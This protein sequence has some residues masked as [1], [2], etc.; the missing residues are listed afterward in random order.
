VRILVLG[1][2]RFLGRGAVDAA[3]ARGHQVTLFN[4]GRSS[5]ELYP[6]VEHLRGDRDG[7]LTPL[8]GRDFDA[9]IDTSGFLPRVVRASCELLSDSVGHYSFVSTVGVYDL[10]RANTEE[11]WTKEPDW[12]T[13][14]PTRAP[15]S[16]YQQRKLACE[17]V[18]Q[19]AF[20]RRAF[21]PRPG[22]IVGAHDP[23]RRL[24]YW[25]LRLLRGGDVLA[26]APRELPVQ[27]IDAADLGDWMVQASERGVAGVFTATGPAERLT[28]ESFLERIRRALGSH[29]RL[30]WVET[31]VLR[32]AGLKEWQDIPFW[33]EDPAFAGQFSFD[34]SKAVSAGFRYRPLEESV[35]S[36]REWLQREGRLESELGLSIERERVLLRP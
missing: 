2:T 21:I 1:G 23:A 27:L 15:S 22:A 29:A 11:S 13:E 35:A 7:D 4:R 26:P 34:V 12:A 5:P 28:M 31:E 14:E 6:E 25:I 16:A 33:T 8:R 30:V 10:S 24:D 19:E 36:L 9:A 18:V 3:L 32:A 17:L 20:P